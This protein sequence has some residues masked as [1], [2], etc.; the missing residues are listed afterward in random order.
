[1]PIDNLGVK[2]ITTA[3]IT[4][5]DASLDR[6]IEI[7]NEITQSFSDEERTRYGSIN[8]KNKLLANSVQDYA[9]NQPDLRSPD[10]N[11]VEFNADYADRK[12]ADTRLNKLAQAARLISDFKIAHDYDNYHAALTDY[13]Y[14][15]YKAGAGVPGFTEKAADLKQFFPNTGGGSTPPTTPTT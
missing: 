14:T 11:W 6:L 9:T 7:G 5:F 10:V 1:M 12:F 3:Q 4:E 8:E 15:K 2:H 13:D